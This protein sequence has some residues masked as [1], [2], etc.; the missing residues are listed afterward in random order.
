[1]QA[2]SNLLIHNLTLMVA[3]FRQRIAVRKRLKS[4]CHNEV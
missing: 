1:M 2:V 3:Q 4:H